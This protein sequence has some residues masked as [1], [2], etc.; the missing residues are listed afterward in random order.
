ME[1]EYFYPD[2]VIVVQTESGRVAKLGY[3]TYL[4]A[5]GEVQ[6][7]SQLP[8]N[9]TDREVYAI[10]RIYH[11]IWLE[12]R[13]RHRKEQAEIFLAS[14]PSVQKDTASWNSFISEGNE[15]SITA[16][17]IWKENN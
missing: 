11:K 16:W 15:P 8:V 4:N 5:S 7:K 13:E 1:T 14:Y 9:F 17:N 2:D 10:E 3:T 6:M 12:A